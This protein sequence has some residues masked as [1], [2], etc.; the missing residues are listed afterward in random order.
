MASSIPWQELYQSPKGNRRLRVL[1]P[2]TGS[3][4]TIVVAR[5][6][7]H[8]AIGFDTDPLAILLAR[9]WC[10]DVTENSIRH[11]AEWV[12]KRATHHAGKIPVRLAYP[13][14]TDDE[15][16][17]F[18]RY[19][20]NKPNRRQLAALAQSISKIRNNTVQCILW[21][22]FSRLIITK[23]AGASRAIDVSHSRPHRAP[24]NKKPVRPLNHFMRNVQ[25]VITAMP[26]KASDKNRPLAL[27][28]RADARHLPLRSS[29]VDVVISSPPYINAID[30]LRG[31]KFSLVWMGH[32]IGEIRQLRAS[33]I[34]T[35][36]S[37]G[38]D[39]GNSNVAAAL[40]KMGNLDR[41]PLREKCWLARYASDMD[42]SMEEIARVLVPKGRL[43][44]VVGDQTIR[45]LYIRNSRALAYLGKRHGF[46]LTRLRR[47]TIPPNRRY[48]PPP[49]YKTSG[50]SFQ[51]R[52]RTEV[53]LEF[54]KP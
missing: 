28:R 33:N 10:S 40:G 44:L 29:T 4:T 36:V 25:S 49:S 19:W 21:C 53:L 3:G 18:V 27:V 47:R 45:G 37:A 20:F 54:T 46:R 52:L 7:G 48:L 42:K 38:V 35:E 50:P 22:A 43:I 23:Q 14:N 2:M 31:H 8:E 13:L 24:N 9:T 12:Y 51:S 26:F 11:A 16:R 39:F 15:T 41:L 1:D 30:Y 32:T 17:A 6:L 5:A 34:G